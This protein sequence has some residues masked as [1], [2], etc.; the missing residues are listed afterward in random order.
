VGS[1]PVSVPERP[2]AAED[3]DAVADAREDRLEKGSLVSC[4]GLQRRLPIEYPS[5]N[6]VETKR[7]RRDSNPRRR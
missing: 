5:F 1:G 6:R 2:V 4:F 7:R 3:D